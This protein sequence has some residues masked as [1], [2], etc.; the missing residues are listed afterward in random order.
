MSSRSTSKASACCATRWPSLPR[1]ME[2]RES[3]KDGVVMLGLAGRLDAGSAPA[4]QERFQNLI[5]QGERRFVVD[6]GELTYVSSY[7]MRLLLDTAR[8]LEPPAGSIVLCSVRAP[9]R[10]V[11]DIAG[12]ASL[13]RIFDSSEEAVRHYQAVD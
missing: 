11:L 13:F 7:G 3:R 8:T 2:I 4:L 1:K 12:L 10:R 9:V 5:G 6:G